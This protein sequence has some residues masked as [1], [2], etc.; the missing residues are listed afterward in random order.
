[1]VKNSIIMKILIVPLYP[2]VWLLTTP[3]GD[4]A[5]YMLYALL[6]AKKGM[7]RRNS[8]GDDI[9][10]KNFPVTEGAQKALWDHTVS[11]TSVGE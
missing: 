6:S 1:M 4:C 10:L 7:N 8:K 2:L 9:G 3:R 11:V 5:E